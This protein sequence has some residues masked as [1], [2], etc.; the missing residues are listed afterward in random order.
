VEAAKRNTSVTVLVNE[1][2]TKMFGDLMEDGNAK[3]AAVCVHC[4]HEAEAPAA[5]QVRRPRGRPRKI[6]EPSVTAPAA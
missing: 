3:Q 4:E 5:K 2:L 1:A 6:R